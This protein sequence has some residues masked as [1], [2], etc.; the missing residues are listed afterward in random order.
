MTREQLKAYIF[1]TYGVAEDYPWENDNTSAVF[2][3]IENKKWFAIMMN[4]PAAKL[5]IDSEKRI[6]IVNVKCDNILIGS[7]IKESGFYPAYHMNKS[8]WIT[9]AL[10]GTADDEKIKWIVDMSFEATKIKM[11]NKSK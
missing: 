5:G 8:Y 6:D 3:H 1:D 4:I 10:D 11:K 2:R 7:L 9:A